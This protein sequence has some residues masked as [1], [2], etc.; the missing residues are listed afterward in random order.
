ML[1]A[2]LKGTEQGGM[3]IHPSEDRLLRLAFGRFGGGAVARSAAAPIVARYQQSGGDIGSSAIATRVRA[4]GPRWCLWR[5]RICA[6][7]RM[8]GGRATMTGA[9]STVMRANS[10]C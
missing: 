3:S 2:A 1:K 10:G 4:V 8:S 5:R 6:G 9:T 7:I